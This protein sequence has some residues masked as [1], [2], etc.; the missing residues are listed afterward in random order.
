[1]NGLEMGYNDRGK[2]EI[3][4]YDRN[5]STQVLDSSGEPLSSVMESAL[6][7]VTVFS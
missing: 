6:G 1:M 4:Q 3:V 5:Q 2:L 7:S